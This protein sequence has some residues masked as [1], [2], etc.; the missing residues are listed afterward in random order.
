VLLDCADARFLFLDH[1]CHGLADLIRRVTRRWR[2]G[3]S[4]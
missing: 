4:G 2:R 3:A 1:L